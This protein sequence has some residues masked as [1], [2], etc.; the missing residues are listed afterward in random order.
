VGSE[1]CGWGGLKSDVWRCDVTVV[2]A[3]MVG[4]VA[5]VVEWCVRACG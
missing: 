2:V 1:A 5:V 3:V 4:L